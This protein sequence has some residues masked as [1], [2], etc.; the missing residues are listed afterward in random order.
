MTLEHPRE[1]CGLCGVSGGESVLA[2][3]HLGLHALQHRGQEAAGVMLAGGGTCF[4]HRARGLVDDAFDGLPPVMRG[5]A[6]ERAIAHVRYSTAGDSSAANAQPLM[7]EIAGQKLGIAHNGTLCNAASLRLE[8]LADGAILQTTSDTELVLHLIARALRKRPATQLWDAVAESLTRLK[9]AYAFLLLTKDCMAA[10]RDPMGFRPLSI[11]DLPDDGCLVA[12]ETIAH[13]VTGARPVREVE[14][15]EMVIWGP[16]GRVESR[17]FA[18]CV[19]RA[20]CIFEHVYFARPGSYVFGDSVYEV[21]KAMGRQLA[22][23]APVAADVVIPVPDSGTFAA[24]GFAEESKLPFDMGFTR[25]HYV[26]RTFIDPGQRLSRRKLV[27]RKL[28]PIAEAVAGRRVCLVEDSIVRGN[29][30]QARVRTLRDA[31]A[32]EV[33][34]RVSCPPHR[35]GCYFGIDFP[36][37]GQLLANQAPLEQMRERL[38]L[39][40]LAYLSKDGMLSCVRRY[41]PEDYCCACFDGRYPVEP[42]TLDERPLPC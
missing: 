13:T 30:C 17:R 2:L 15:G 4:L 27:A 11:G 42:D 36:E 20:H 39:D 19:R 34:M 35:C 41:R 14:P 1:H 25:N 24:L 9:G 5:L 32:R 31:G 8:L 23:E 18:P 37:S 10:V 33:H 3:T 29:T 26:G 38:R 28:Q 21:R 7:V 40:S 12:S 16:G 22:R 6:A